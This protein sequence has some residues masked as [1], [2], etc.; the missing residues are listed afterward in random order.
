[1]GR[2]PP[3]GRE[4]GWEGLAEGL[5]L[6][7]GLGLGLAAAG[8]ASSSSPSSPSSSSGAP[9]PRL[10]MMKVVLLRAEAT[11]K[12]TKRLAALVLQTA[13]RTMGRYYVPASRNMICACATFSDSA[14]SPTWG[15]RLRRFSGG[16]Q[17]LLVCLIHWVNPFAA[18]RA[19]LLSG[20]TSLMPCVGACHTVAEG[21]V[22]FVYSPWWMVLLTVKR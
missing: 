2:A 11:C 18:T 14:A 5:G 7:L 6:P 13:M 1:M 16:T 4:A 17:H 8:A 12:R 19:S 20:D 21:G 22:L 9:K 10:K 15:S 3:A